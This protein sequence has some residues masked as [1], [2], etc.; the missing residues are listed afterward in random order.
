[1]K[2]VAIFVLFLFIV[3]SYSTGNAEIYWKDYYGSISSDAIPAGIDK[4]GNPTYIGQFPISKLPL[5]QT[6]DTVLATISKSDGRAYGVYKLKVLFSRENVKILCSN[7]INRNSNRPDMLWSNTFMSDCNLVQGGSS[8]NT[9]IPLYIGR[10]NYKGQNVT[11]TFWK[12]EAVLNVPWVT[13]NFEEASVFQSNSF[14]MLYSCVD[15][16]RT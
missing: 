7:G 4:F 14:E 6:A 16:V 11:G 15:G 1:M 12:D 10:T 5:D 8:S 3:C 2:F 9:S 13:S